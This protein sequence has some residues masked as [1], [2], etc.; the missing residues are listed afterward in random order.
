MFDFFKVFKILK[1]LKVF[2]VFKDFKGFEAFKDGKDSAR[3]S[4]GA[5]R[6]MLTAH[7]LLPC[8]AHHLKSEYF[9]D[10]INT[11]YKGYKEDGDGLVD[12]YSWC[13]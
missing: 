10:W 1:V 11:D 7:F 13:Y 3:L 9:I 12:K 4:F 8:C 2:E 6:L 5:Q